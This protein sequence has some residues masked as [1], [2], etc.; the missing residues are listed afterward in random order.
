MERLIRWF[1]QLSIP[2]TFIIYMFLCL[3]IALILSAITMNAVDNRIAV[4]SASYDREGSRYYLTT[5]NGRQLGEGVN[6]Y[7]DDVNYSLEDQRK[8]K[9][10]SVVSIVAIPLYFTICIIVS[11]FVFYRQKMKR[12]LAFLNKATEKM[13]NQQL[14]FTIEYPIQDELGRLC[15]SFEMMRSSLET[16]HRYLWRMIEDRKQLNEAF[17]HDLRTPLT[18]LK[19]Y[20]DLMDNYVQDQQMSKQKMIEMIATM[21]VQVN[22]L[23]NYASSMHA[24][25]KLEAMEPNKR[26]IQTSL[27]I[28]QI[29][30]VLLILNPAQSVN[31][32][33][34]QKKEFCEL[35]I[36]LAMQVF[37]NLL[38]N[39]IRYAKNTIRITLTI[40]EYMLYLMIQDDGEGFSPESLIRAMEPYYRS[41]GEERGEHYG[42]GLYICNLICTKHG[43]SL[44]IMNDNL[45]G[46][47]VIAS[48]KVT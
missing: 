24:L 26:S 27:I 33:V 35:D 36:D 3:L 23:E 40:E 19:G 7:V 1:K 32:D 29:K 48:F 13:S 11:S 25:Q 8:L 22:R 39:A 18:V 20:I 41:D 37:E 17:A 38:N 46:A 34:K 16:N 45:T 43:G 15:G 31:V 42:L 28:Q 5:E 4:I 12:P 47:V 10:L 21:N 44:K 14:D 2:T 30:D 9:A 6:I